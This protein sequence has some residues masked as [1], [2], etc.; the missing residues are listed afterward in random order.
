MPSGTPPSLKLG[1]R[2]SSDLALHCISAPPY[3]HPE[4][5]LK[6]WRRPCP[7]LILKSILDRLHNNSHLF[8]QYLLLLMKVEMM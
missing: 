2:G 8:R 4:F 1:S 7:R 5:L 3:P 6:T